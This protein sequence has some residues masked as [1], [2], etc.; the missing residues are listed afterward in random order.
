M[1]FTLLGATKF[2]AASLCLIHII[3]VYRRSRR[4]HQPVRYS[5]LSMPNQDSWRWRRPDAELGLTLEDEPNRSVLL[6]PVRLLAFEKVFIAA[7]YLGLVASL[8]LL[9]VDIPFLR[10]AFQMGR[11]APPA[12][13]HEV[14]RGRTTAD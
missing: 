3:R 1:P 14:F 13:M 10:D 5:E 9:V 4:S 7:G 12:R 2:A 6:L 8:V 11:P